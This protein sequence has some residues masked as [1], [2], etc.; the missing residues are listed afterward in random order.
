MQSHEG[1]G[2]ESD[3]MMKMYQHAAQ[4]DNEVSLL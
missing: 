1:K 4:Y 3:R 2:K